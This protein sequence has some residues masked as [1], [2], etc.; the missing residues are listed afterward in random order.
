MYSSTRPP[1]KDDQTAAGECPQDRQPDTR[2]LDYFP[3]GPDCSA[4]S[5]NRK[6]STWAYYDPLHGNHQIPV[7]KVPD[8]IE[9][10]VEDANFLNAIRVVGKAPE[11]APGYGYR[12]V[13]DVCAGSTA[14]RQ[15]GKRYCSNSFRG[16]IAL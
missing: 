14:S 1:R 2:L 9:Q 11:K 3:G 13:G 12:S 4:S 8:L 10:I 7:V 5:H 15:I 16:H 6:A